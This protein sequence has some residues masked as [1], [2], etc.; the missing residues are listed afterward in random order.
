M[1]FGRPETFLLSD[2]QNTALSPS[3]GSAGS[4]S[5]G[6]QGRMDIP[7][8]PRSSH[9]TSVCILQTQRP[10]V[11]WRSMVTPVSEV[12]AEVKCKTLCTVFGAK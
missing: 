10:P 7:S 2:A 5:L 4:L 1:T 3:L 6:P 8:P 9:S 11:G 12:V